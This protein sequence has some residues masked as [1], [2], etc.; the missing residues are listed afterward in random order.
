MNLTV[1]FR[2]LARN[3]KLAAHLQK[4]CEI[5]GILADSGTD[6]TLLSVRSNEKHDIHTLT[7]IF[8]FE[9]SRFQIQR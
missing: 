4:P 6:K 5:Y 7:K 8:E 2:N 1:E 9:K 3:Y